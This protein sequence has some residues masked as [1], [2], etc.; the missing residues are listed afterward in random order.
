MEFL[1]SRLLKLM[2]NIL[3]VVHYEQSME[4]VRPKKENSFKGVFQR[5]CS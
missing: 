5:F 3:R 2:S 1:E 4:Y